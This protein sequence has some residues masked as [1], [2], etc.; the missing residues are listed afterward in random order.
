VALELQDGHPCRDGMLTLECDRER[1]ESGW[2]DGRDVA[3]DYYVACDR[4]G[5]RLWIYR[6]LT[7]ARRWLL[8][9]IFA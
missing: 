1:I 9:G 3:R 4:Q 7:G 8:H 5:A 6:E 2:W